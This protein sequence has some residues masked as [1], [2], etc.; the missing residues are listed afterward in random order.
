MCDFCKEKQKDIEGFINGY[1]DL[2][3][4]D[5]VDEIDALR[6]ELCKHKDTCRESDCIAGELIAEIDTNHEIK[7]KKGLL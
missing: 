2:Y 7:K 4:R 3:P 5:V 6:N 1:G